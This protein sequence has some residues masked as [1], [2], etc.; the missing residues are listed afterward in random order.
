M[1]RNKKVVAG[2]GAKFQGPGK[3]ANGGTLVAATRTELAAVQACPDYANQP[4]LAGEVELVLADNAALE[5]TV[6][7]IASLRTR[8][9]ALEA[10]RDGQ[11]NKV[12]RGRRNLEGK[13][14]CIC[15]GDVEAIKAWGCVPRTRSVRAP[16]TDPPV[17]LTAKP[18][19]TTP[20]TFVAQCR[21]IPGAGSYLFEVTSDPTTL[22]GSG[23]VVVST[24]ASQVFAGQPLGH[25]VYLRVAA[26]RRSGGQS[27][28]SEAV[29]ITVR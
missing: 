6:D 18:S 24:R 2:A 22:P 5:L 4:A 12:W 26:L 13:L 27:E 17:G 1:A 14:T 7:E 28:W 20:G 8:L 25:S 21:A 11:M 9:T 10:T 29:Q 23:R 16:S 19:K 3:D 15:A